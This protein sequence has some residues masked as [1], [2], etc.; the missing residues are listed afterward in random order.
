MHGILAALI[1]S[2]RRCLAVTPHFDEVRTLDGITCALDLITELVGILVGFLLT[3]T[4]YG[5][6]AYGHCQ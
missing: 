1:L 2:H 5:R 3:D 6:D 4:G